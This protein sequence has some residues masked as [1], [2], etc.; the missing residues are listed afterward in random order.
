MYLQPNV[1]KLSGNDEQIDT[2]NSICDLAKIKTDRALKLR[3]IRFT[4][5]ERSSSQCSCGTKR[6][7]NQKKSVK[8]QTS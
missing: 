1:T 6:K 7:V 8:P 4:L 3:L 5:K 2:E